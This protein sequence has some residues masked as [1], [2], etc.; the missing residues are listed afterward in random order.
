MKTILITGAGRRFGKALATYWLAQG[1][2]VLAHYNTV[3]ELEPNER[4]VAFQADLACADSVVSLCQ[5]LTDW[6]QEHEVRLDGLIHNASCFVPDAAFGDDLREH[7]AHVQRHFHVHVG[8]PYLLMEALKEQWAEQATVVAISDIY[9]DIPNQR[10]AAYCA[11]K[12]GLQNLALSQAQR[13]AGK[14]R[15]NV[16][17]PGPVKF[18]PEHSEAYRQQVLSQ[19]LIRE[20]LGYDAV[21][22]ACAYLMNA[23]AVTGTVM[24]VDGGR[25]VANRYEQTFIHD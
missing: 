15:V 13:L 11:S 7:A 16:V 3:N 25:F 8:A 24:R 6:L 1:W 20:E 5:Q 14:V 18:L 9:S 22:D 23:R 17:Q 2:R 12:A 10:F 21:L 4:V 19:S